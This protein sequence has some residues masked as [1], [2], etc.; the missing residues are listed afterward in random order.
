MQSFFLC[1]KH[2][3]LTANPYFEDNLLYFLLS[4]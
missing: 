3:M 1:E 4:P 2:E